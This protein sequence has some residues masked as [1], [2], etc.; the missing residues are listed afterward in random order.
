VF[1]WQEQLDVPGGRVGRVAGVVAGRLATPFFA[2][3]L[4]RLG[5]LA[6]QDGAGRT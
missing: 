1:T 6:T 2:L 5:R 4:W 3:A